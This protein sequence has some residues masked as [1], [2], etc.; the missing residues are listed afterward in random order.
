[1]FHT[2]G[3]KYFPNYLSHFITSPELR[4]EGIAEFRDA[5][6]HWP[7]FALLTAIGE[8]DDI[9]IRSVAD[10]YLLRRINFTLAHS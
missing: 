9:R 4:G 1:M 10:V 2:K 6:I 3:L 5:P 7:I 8:E